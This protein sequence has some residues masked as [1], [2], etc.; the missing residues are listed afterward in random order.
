MLTKR[1]IPCLDVN[2][3][4]VV[5]GVNFVNLQDAGDPVEIAKAA[6]AHAREHGNDL[7]FLD[8]A[9]RLHV[10][11]E[12]MDELRRIKA[13]VEPTEILL[14]VDAMIG[15]DAVNAA[16]AFDDALDI[17]GVVLTK[18]DGDARGGAALSIKAVTGKPIKFVGVGEKLDQIEVFH[19]DRMASRI[20]G[21][22]D[23]LSLIEKAEQNF[24]QKKALELQE[25]LRKNKFTLTDFYEQM[26]QLQNM[27]SLTELAGMLPG[28]KASDLEGADLNNGMFKQ[29][30]AIIQS[31][32]P[33]ERD[34]PSI[35]N[36]SRKK[37]IAAGCGLTVEQVNRLLKQFEAMQKMTKQ[38]TGMARGKGKKK[39]RGF[40]GLGGLGGM[41]LP[42]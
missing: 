6:I 16:K 14:V 37:R 1:I 39:R 9:G 19:P 24:D 34:N 27:G 26:A 28:V 38:L 32:T 25:K 4:R 12:L 23:V 30:S 10:D 8:T 3:G 11:E 13:A 35:I 42:F 21:M 22:G 33:K 31:M 41:K 17:D 20:L 2:D 5:K 15:Q 7:V 36:F 18:L 40:P 29:M